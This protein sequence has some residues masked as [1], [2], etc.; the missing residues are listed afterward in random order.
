[1]TRINALLLLAVVATAIYLVRVQYES[2]R[3]F[4]ELDKA[5]SQA[6]H[7]AMDVERLE[8]EKRAQASPGRVERLAR[9]KLEMRQPNPGPWQATAWL[10][11]SGACAPFFSRSC[12]F[13][14]P[15]VTRW[16]CAA[17][18]RHPPPPRN[19]PAPPIRATPWSS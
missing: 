16:W 4:S 12:C 14:V 2:R 8:V 6:R 17:A 19:T 3:L 7:L 9:E 5:H 13:W 11:I 18:W 10:R 15:A 1:M